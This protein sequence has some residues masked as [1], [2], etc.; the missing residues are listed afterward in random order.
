MNAT[1]SL[2]ITTPLATV[3]EADDVASLRAEDASGDF[4]IMPGHADFLTVMEA[5]VLRWRSA[6]GCWRF[7]ALR[8]GV[9]TVTGGASISIACREAVVSDELPS[10]RAD[11]A[12][13]KSEATEAARAARSHRVRLHARAVREIM[14]RMGSGLPDDT[15]L[16]EVFE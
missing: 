3:V 14:R 1:L 7:A 6:G 2:V 9:L 12:R 15:L 4:G 8:G 16:T 11:V 5:A 10:L 13:A